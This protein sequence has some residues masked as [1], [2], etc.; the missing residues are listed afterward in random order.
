MGK[1][2]HKKS[3]PGVRTRL[4]AWAPILLLKKGLHKNVKKFV[5]QDIVE[6]NRATSQKLVEANCCCDMKRGRQTRSLTERS[7]KRHTQKGS[8]AKTT[9]I[10]AW[11][12][13]CPRLHPLRNSRGCTLQDKYTSPKWSSPITTH[14]R[15]QN[16]KSPGVGRYLELL[17]Y[18]V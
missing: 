18:R 14:I 1:E 11:L 9:V 5:T 13:A 7:R 10:P 8:I 15:K 3:P 2:R 6:N 17:K 4:N 12:Y 16:N